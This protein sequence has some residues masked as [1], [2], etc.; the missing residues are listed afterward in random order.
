MT[1]SVLD[2]I[3]KLK[4]AIVAL[5]NQRSVLGEEVVDNAV[6]VFQQQ[7]AALQSQKAARSDE[8]ERRLLTI[9]LSD[10]VGSTQHAEN[11]D[12]EEWQGLI[13]LLLDEQSK[14]IARNG[15]TVIHSLGDGLIAL[16][17]L[18]NMSENAPENAISTALE[19]QSRAHSGTAWGGLQ[20]R[21][22]IHTGMVFTSQV[23][24]GVHRKFTAIGDA[25]NLAE[26]IQ[27][28]APPAGVLISQD[29]YMQVRGMF[30][31]IAQPALPTKEK[32][33]TLDTYLV[34]SVRQR[35]FRTGSRGVAGIEINTVGREVEFKQLQEAYDS[36]CKDGGVRWAQ[37]IGEPG[38]GKS[39]LMA[40]FYRWAERQPF[41]TRIFRSRAFERE[42]FL[43]FALIRQMW[44]DL[45]Q[46]SE[47]MSLADAETKWVTA[48]R[49]VSAIQDLEPAHI[50]GL[51]VGLP[52]LSSP[53]IGE[54]RH[55]PIQLQGRAFAISREVFR[56]IRA[57]NTVLV[58]LEDLHWAD[59]SSLEYLQAVFL[60]DWTLVSTRSWR[61]NESAAQERDNAAQ[62]GYETSQGMFILATARPTWNPPEKLLASL[63][64]GN[65]AQGRSYPLST[66]ALGI[67]LSRLPAE[68]MAELTRQLVAKVANMPAEV[69]ERIVRQAE[70][71]PYFAEELINWFIDKGVIDR[72]AEPW[73]FVP[74]QLRTLVLPTTLQQL[75]L[76]RLWTLS[77]AERYALQRGSIFGRRFWT[78]GIEALGQPDAD[79]LLDPLQHR[80]LVE[81]EPESAFQGEMEWSFHHNLL[82]EVIYDSVLKRER[83]GFHRAAAGWLERIALGAN[84]LDEFAGI[85]G[86][87]CERAGD[88][89]AAAYWFIQAGERAQMSGAL[90]EAQR[91]FS[92]ALELAPAEDQPTRWRALLGRSLVSDSCGEWEA[93]K[94]N[95][96]E[97]LRLAV[98]LNDAEGLAQVHY[99]Q[100][101]LAWGQGDYRQAIQRADEALAAARLSGRQALE[102]R[103]MGIKTAALTRLGELAPAK[104][105]VD[106]I[107]ARV[108]T[109]KDAAAAAFAIERIPFYYYETGDMAMAVQ[110]FTR[111][112]ELAQQAGDRGMQ[113]SVMTNLG[114]VYS[115]FGLFELAR[116]TQEQALVLHE[117]V[118]SRPGHAYSLMNLGW[119]HNQIG[120]W[121][122]AQQL[123]EQTLAELNTIGDDWGRGCCL[124]ILGEIAEYARQPREAAERYTAARLVFE[125]V[126]HRPRVTEMLAGLARCARMQG[127]LDEGSDLVGQVWEFLKTYGAAGMDWPARVYQTVGVILAEANRPAEAEAAIEAGYREMME[128]VNRINNIEWRRSMLENISENRALDSMWQAIH[129]RP[130]HGARRQDH[131]ANSLDASPD[132][133]C[134]ASPDASCD[135]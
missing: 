129:K 64:K 97:L 34:R 122:L 108:D 68:K 21:I 5:E 3:Q 58:L 45:F 70:G 67:H 41:W 61:S 37:L 134:G 59:A 124:Q 81:I 99:L 90:S 49:E 60:E 135:A 94:A 25:M 107:L 30:D 112:L 52:F 73:R 93:Q 51:L 123:E 1:N 33:D 92:R 50:L 24:S 100:T 80:C 98:A 117:A 40:D 106:E 127:N 96:S 126:G 55:N 128:G 109:V 69:I 77:D 102:M 4:Q 13:T 27:K 20:L 119:I 113:A 79:H 35:S 78:G 10:V 47:D 46:I 16:F 9:F 62:P 57:Q 56:R 7:L 8:Q 63:E 19:I 103:A 39:R 42:H 121:K 120:N 66:R 82:R 74:E 71:V 114:V 115:G 26:R 22:G 75:L 18:L 110:L 2:Q 31:V 29:T 15:G 38:V 125:Q 54:L 11:M 72:Q 14:M 118:G 89:G 86:E 23:G 85:I 95:L 76:T 130:A 88:S 111:T 12:P 133:S 132:T 43:P 84:R 116:A 32:S 105:L 36:V 28:A 17:G 44:F 131:S 91:F 87:H 48:F 101:R 83:P 53:S 104:Q 65:A 6:A